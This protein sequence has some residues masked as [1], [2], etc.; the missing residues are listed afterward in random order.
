MGGGGGS[1]EQRSVG[2]E[3]VGQELT[4]IIVDLHEFFLSSFLLNIFSFH[5]LQQGQ[6]RQTI[7]FTM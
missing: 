4:P 7:Q 6:E 3:E 1:G 5:Q 2:T